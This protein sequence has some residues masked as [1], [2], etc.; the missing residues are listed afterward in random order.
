MKKAFKKHKTYK[1][2][3]YS[4][5]SAVNQYSHFKKLENE[6][7]FK[8]DSNAYYI[9]RFDGKGMTKD[10]RQGNVAINE[11]FFNT[12]KEIF[13]SFCSNNSYIL[14][15]YSCNDE[16]SILI[17]ATSGIKSI[18]SRSEKILSLLASELSVLFYKNA[19]KNNL[20][21]KRD[22]LFDARLIKLEEKDILN[23]F[24]SRQAFA[25][26]EYVYRLR[27]QYNINRNLKNTKDILPELKKKNINYFGLPFEYRYGLIYS[28]L[29][30]QIKPFDFSGDLERLETL[31]FYKKET[32][33]I[34][35]TN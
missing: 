31:V 6:F 14:F 2:R 5:P 34:S 23:Y 20:A 35:K 3:N 8:L 16:I 9:V 11:T 27:N 29:K 19:I 26:Y 25:I 1:M 24:C 4:Q 13:K 15:A 30:K 7:D 28:P 10:Y 12:M 33:P 17:K 22:S 18:T 32:Q 21:L